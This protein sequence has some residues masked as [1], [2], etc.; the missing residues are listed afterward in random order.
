MSDRT[1]APDHGFDPV[2]ETWRNVHWRSRYNGQV[3]SESE[4]RMMPLPEYTLL[5]YGPFCEAY[6]RAKRMKP[7]AGSYGLP[8]RPLRADDI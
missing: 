5:R 7:Y 8:P 1:G 4:L 6:I 3:Y 2:T